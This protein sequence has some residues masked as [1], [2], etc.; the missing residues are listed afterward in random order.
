MI[1]IT[2]KITLI[3]LIMT[4]MQY[5]LGLTMSQPP[6]SFCHHSTF[7][8][9]ESA[10]EG[11]WT[12]LVSMKRK[13]AWENLL[14]GHF[15]SLPEEGLCQ[16]RPL[17]NIFMLCYFT[18]LQIPPLE[19]FVKL[20]FPTEKGFSSKQCRDRATFVGWVGIAPL[21]YLHWTAL[22]AKCRPI[23]IIQLDPFQKNHC[24]ERPS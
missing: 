21:K 1:I 12:N 3:I 20:R 11:C 9:T 15:L 10:L 2:I 13:A 24:T 8:R 23:W 16:H 6:F 18:P 5:V 22:F 14:S 7:E 17:E 19:H 4:I